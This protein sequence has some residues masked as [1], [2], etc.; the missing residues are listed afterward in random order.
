[1]NLSEMSPLAL[2][3]LHGAIID[4]LKKR[5]IARTNNS[6]IGDYVEWLVSSELKLKLCDN[7]ESGYDAI[8]SAGIRYQIKSRR[9][10]QGESSAQL[11]AIRKLDQ[12]T[13]TFDFIIA[14]GLNPDFTLRYAAQIPHAVVKRITKHNDHTNSGILHLRDSLFSEAGV[15]EIL[16]NLK[17]ESPSDQIGYLK[18]KFVSQTP[19]RHDPTMP[20][21]PAVPRHKIIEQIINLESQIKPIGPN[22]FMDL[23]EHIKKGGAIDRVTL[24]NELQGDNDEPSKS[25]I[26][27]HFENVMDDQD[28]NYILQ[29]LAGLTGKKRRATTIER[30]IHLL[31]MHYPSMRKEAP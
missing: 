15:S 30:A 20:S 3:Q 16:Q 21:N 1:M 2:L 28:L 14:I 9:F 5:E 7:S 24:M 10:N 12:S 18:Q 19:P 6:P 26:V 4:E 22:N 13:P 8:D 25:S 29:S 23:F 27:T 31:E 11:S 17:K